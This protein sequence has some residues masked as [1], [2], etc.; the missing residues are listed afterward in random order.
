MALGEQRGLVASSLEGAIGLALMELHYRNAPDA[1]RHRVEAAL[2]QRPLASIPAADRPYLGLAWFYAEAGQPARAT[3][4]LA[5]YDA[6]VPEG[7]RRR[8]PFRY[9]AAAA[10]AFAQGHVQEAIREYRAWYAADNCAVCGLFYLARAYEQAGAVDSAIA[11]YER[12]VNTPGLTRLYEEA[13][14]LALTYKRL[15]E[16]Y[17]KRGD[18]ARA[19]DYYG[20]FVDLWKNADAELQP[21]VRDVRARIIRLTAEPKS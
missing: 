14:T 1:A 16:L 10:T 13:P 20:R 2:R 4:L 12:A 21:Q 7:L 5:E 3:Q 15:G 9:G 8:Q 17:D 11:V 18:A 19:R 6:A